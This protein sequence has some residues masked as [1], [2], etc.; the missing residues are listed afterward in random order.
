MKCYRIQDDFGLENLVQTE[1]PDPS[2]D[3]SEVLVDIRAVSLNFRDV[4]TVNGSYNP[5]QPLPLIPCSDAAGVVE[6]VGDDVEEFEPGDRVIP[7][8]AQG[9]QE[10]ELTR[11]KRS[12]TLGGPLPGTLTEKRAFREQGLVHAP[13]NLDFSEACTIPC[14]GV[15]AWVALTNFQTLQPG[16]RVL[17]LGTGGVST[18]GLLIAKTIGAE[19]FITSSSDQKLEQMESLGADHTINYEDNPDWDQVVLDKTNGEG[20]D[21]VLEV[22]GEQT[23]SKSLNSAAFGGQVSLIGVLS[24]AQPELNLASA[25]MKRVRVQGILVGSRQ[26][27]VE[28]SRTAEQNDIQPVANQVFDFDQ[29]REA[30]EYVQTGKHTGKVVIEL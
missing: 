1:V 12:T 22:G 20:V 19:V 24:G 4:M 23:L 26:D 7:A 28:F 6:S 27:L 3:P 29:A 2:C 8:F 13:N 18:F 16:Q 17:L 30:F 9:W 11:E 5:D 14:A 10:G 15:T 25:L 21:H